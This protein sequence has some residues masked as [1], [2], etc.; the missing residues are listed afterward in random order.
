MLAQ[1]TASWWLEVIIEI[2][3]FFYID[4]RPFSAHVVSTTLK[5]FISL[6][7]QNHLECL[8]KLNDHTLDFL[9]H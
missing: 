1:Q 8:S 4:H 9:I 2:F 3:F 6:V 5:T 7:H